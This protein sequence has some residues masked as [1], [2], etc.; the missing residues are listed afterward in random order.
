MR[1]HSNIKTILIVL[2]VASLFFVS[3]I[4]LLVKLNLTSPTLI[5]TNRIL[6]TL[7]EA[8]SDITFS[9][10]GMERNFRDRVMI[11]DFSLYYKGDIIAAFDT[12]EVKLGLFDIISY[13]L[14]LEGGAEI[15]F[16]D[17]SVTFSSSMFISNEEE[18]TGTSGSLPDFSSFLSSH[19]LT[20][21]F[22]NITIESD[23]VSGDLDKFSVTYIGKEDMAI[24]EIK[25]PELSLSNYGFDIKLNQSDLSFKLGETIF[26]KGSVKNA[27]IG[28]SEIRGEVDDISFSLSS[29]SIE[30]LTSLVFNAALYTK[31][32]SLEEEENKVTLSSSFFIYDESGINGELDSALYEKGDISLSSNKIAL[33]LSD[34]DKY[35]LSLPAVKGSNGREEMT[36]SGLTLS[37]SIAESNL[38]FMLESISS[39][40]SS[41]SGDVFSSVSLSSLSG[42]FD[43]KEGYKLSLSLMSRI[44]T[45]NEKIDDISFSLEAAV[46]LI[47]GKLSESRLYIKDLYLGYGDIHNSSFTFNGDLD[48][49]YITFDYGSFDVDLLLSVNKKTLS[50]S[51]L[52]LDYHPYSLMPLFGLGDNSPF[53]NESVFSFSSYLNLSLDDANKAGGTVE[54]NADLSILKVSFIESSLSSKGKLKIESDRINLNDIT[55]STSYFDIL[56]GGFFDLEKMLPSIDFT[57]TLKSGEPLIDGYV[58]LGEKRS[59]LFSAD[60]KALKNTRISGEVD[61]NKE[62]IVSSSP[63]LITDGVRRPF[64]LLL[65]LNDKT[66]SL[67]SNNLKFDLSYSDGISGSISAESLKTLRGNDGEAI[68]LDG[69]VDYSFSFNEGIKLSSTRIKVE[70][71]FFIPS[72]PDISFSVNADKDVIN[73]TDITYSNSSVSYSGV[74]K[75]DFLSNI[76][77]FT[78]KE[79]NGEG[80]IILSL[81]KE[82]EYVA[83]FKASDISLSLFGYND[84]KASLILFGRAQEIED[85]SFNG[86]ISVESENNDGRRINAE[87]TIN[88]DRINL[89]NI[90]YSSDDIT[91]TLSSLYFDS[92][93]GRL[94]L[95]NGVLYLPNEKGDRAYPVSLGFELK[96]D[97]E[98]SLSLYSS[99]SSIIQ[100][101]GEG[102]GLEFSL[103][104]LDID[105]SLFR[106][107]DKYFTLKKENNSLLFGGNLIGGSFDLDNKKGEIKVSLD[108]I[109]SASFVLDIDDN[110]S[111]NASIESFNMALVNIF[112]DY[113]VLTFRGDSVSGE[114]A[115]RRVNGEFELSGNL[116]ADELGCDVFWVEDQSL[117]LHNPRFTI[118]DNELKSS[119]TYVTV[120]DHLTGKRKM[121]RMD[122]GVMMSPTLSLERW[123]VDVYIDKDNPVRVRL[124]LFFINIDILGYVYGHYK[125]SSDNIYM[126]NDGDVY[127]LNTTVSIG[128]NDYPEWYNNLSGA[129]LM[130]MSL[131]FLNNN[132]II[133][134][135]GDDPIV[136]VM[137]QENSSVYAHIGQSDFSCSGDVQIRGGEIYYFQKY[138]YIT[139][140]SIS[141]DDPNE[142]N[143]K[144]SLRATLRDYDSSSE[145]VEIYLV[146]KDNTFDNLSPTLESSPAKELSE[147]M[148]ILGQSILP[149]SAYGS[150][151]VSSVAS[152]VTEGFDILSRLGIV[153]TATNPLSSLSSS[154]K[155]V[156]GVDTFSLHSN[157]LNNI[158]TDTISQALNSSVTSYSP[159]A[160]F[161]NGTTLNVG[162][163][164]SQNLYLQMMVHLQAEKNK[165]SYTIISDDLALDTEFSLEWV[166]DAFNLTFFTRPSYFSFYSIMS[167]FGFTIT[168]TINF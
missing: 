58:H 39:D 158:V 37:G 160:R 165:D 168:K 88:S 30:D 138:F 66:F 36:L 119:F 24:A 4:F 14:N 146:M 110:M 49:A 87:I 91:A 143:P 125:A 118:W 9:F 20:L 113:P 86:N 65:N 154:L 151:S 56:L 121:I 59:Y 67:E 44:G 29:K 2:L 109:V 53:S 47:D 156:F 54:Y 149:E 11:R 148:E 26:L 19:N 137:L 117:I 33:S 23:I 84:M 48:K 135:A 21:S 45:I 7:S 147:I 122:V 130:D 35:T 112:F 16:I 141:F 136:S 68:T 163:Y 62:G 164:L 57:S 40:I 139:S 161:L 42:S 132:E 115:L 75:C 93:T 92:R 55:I 99:I 157:I 124:P 10:K 12:I 31:D 120:L 46:N 81:Y 69:R 78:L 100:T 15:D 43:Y 73:L 107:E 51:F 150:V 5:V 114:V 152:L 131:T 104:Y 6:S 159:M 134:P 38:S 145:R 105:S 25:S 85:F 72:S 1:Y 32:I 89:E 27:T 95:E 28:N 52:I 82:E 79:E 74:L 98:P 167:T 13:F 76:L 94:G 123:D 133:Y 90:I 8:E 61:F 70:N 128:M 106:V 71:L 77:A 101:K 64:D 166:N 50:G 127:L 155:N 129:S 108:P 97:V 144:I 63:V 142:F 116:T 60:I 140:G 126:T 80:K 18:N 162:K 83:A 96:G 153:T 41:L 103:D 17:G 34:F 22:E 3:S 102:A 111:I